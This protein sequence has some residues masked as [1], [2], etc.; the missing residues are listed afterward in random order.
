MNNPKNKN[1]K[2]IILLIIVLIGFYS[3]KKIDENNNCE[4]K[5]KSITN[6]E[7]EYGC[8]NTKGQM[9]IDLLNDFTIIKTQI[10]FDSLVSGNCNP[11]IDFN[12][13]DLLIGK[14]GLANGNDT[15]YYELTE[16]CETENLNLK[17]NFINN[18][19]MIAPNITYHSLIPKLKS[20]QS[21]DVEIII[22]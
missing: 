2:N 19:T 3:C 7:S 12:T 16:N 14:K 9:Q 18:M 13:Y 20:G 6:L 11:N 1:M 4:N 17:V 8:V 21:I 22:N 5:K 15:I 10:I